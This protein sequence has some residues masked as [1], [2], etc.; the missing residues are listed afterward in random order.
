MPNWTCA[1]FVLRYSNCRDLEQY[2]EE[3]FCD[4]LFKMVPFLKSKVAL[5]LRSVISAHFVVNYSCWF[6]ILHAFAKAS[7]LTN[8]SSQHKG[9]A[10]CSY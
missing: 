10:S 8:S 1:I 7:F 9:V 6:V 2:F 4:E 5:N 3:L